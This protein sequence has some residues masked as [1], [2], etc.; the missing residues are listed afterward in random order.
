MINNCIAKY[1]IIKNTV[2]CVLVGKCRREQPAADDVKPFVNDHEDGDG[3]TMS[4]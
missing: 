3:D 4:I 1:Y 2:R